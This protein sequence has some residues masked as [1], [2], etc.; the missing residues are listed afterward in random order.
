MVPVSS[1]RWP[2]TQTRTWRRWTF[3]TTMLL[4]C[5]ARGELVDPG[6]PLETETL[7]ADDLC[8]PPE[9]VVCP[10]VRL[11]DLP[12]GPGD[13]PCVDSADC[14]PRAACV[15]STCRPFADVEVTLCVHQTAFVGPHCDGANFV[16]GVLLKTPQPGSFSDDRFP[17]GQALGTDTPG[18]AVTFPTDKGCFAVGLD[19]LIF[20]GVLACPELADGHLD[21]GTW[22]FYAY[23]WHVGTRAQILERLDAGCFDVPENSTIGHR[24]TLSIWGPR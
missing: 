6:P 2:L 21:P 18:C 14:H 13:G 10:E 12:V 4:S 24:S 3:G 7:N 20:D 8:A 19:D 16:H 5:G 1:G 11:T 9:P 23:H 15:A 17:F 22:P